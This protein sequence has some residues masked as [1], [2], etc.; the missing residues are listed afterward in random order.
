MV[1]IRAMSDYDF[2]TINRIEGGHMARRSKRRGVVLEW[3]IEV[4]A[5]I[6]VFAMMLHVSA[7]AL[8][9]SLLDHPLPNTL[10]V[11]QYWYLPIVAL[12][13]FVAAQA[14]GQHI[15]ADLIYERL[16]RSA[17]PV[18]LGVLLLLSAAVCVAFAWY[19]WPE[20]LEAFETRRTA[21]VSSVPVWPVVFLVPAVFAVLSVQMVVAAVQAF[22][23]RAACAMASPDDAVV[24]DQMPTEQGVTR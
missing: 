17:R 23:G 5:V 18:V 8:S 7:N 21:G 11:V 15:A 16:P 24:L 22:R 13:G 6:V 9:R 10:E 19:S 2:M 3:L 14:R 1:V 20:A 12:L 4:P